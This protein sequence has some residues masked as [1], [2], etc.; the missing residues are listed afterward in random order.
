MILAGSFL[1]LVFKSFFTVL[2]LYGEYR[3]SNYKFNV[4]G[5]FQLFIGFSATIVSGRFGVVLYLCF[6]LM[7]F[8]RKVTFAKVSFFF[9]GGIVLMILFYERILLFYS[10][11]LLLRDTLQ[12][13]DPSKSKL[14]LEDYGSEKQDGMYQLSPLTL[15]EEATRPFHDILSYILPNSSPSVVDSGPSFVILNIGLIL[16]ILL[17][18]YFF[19]TIYKSISGVVFLTLLIII[20]DIKFRSVLVLMPTI[21]IM[22][23]LE[24]IK[25]YE[26]I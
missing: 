25:K 22:L 16:F 13:D 6:F 7:I 18:I 2:Y 15:Y 19:K 21:W 8:F 17:Y 26:N 9:M 24:R 12:L 1:A 10:T 14:S 5:Y 3:C 4:F 23:N 11:F 20:M